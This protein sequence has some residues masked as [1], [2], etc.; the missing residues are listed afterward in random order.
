RGDRAAARLPRGT[1]L[2]R[3]LDEDDEP[4]RVDSCDLVRPLQHRP[5]DQLADERHAGA[6]PAPEADL[7][8]ERARVGSVSDAAARPRVSDANIRSAAPEA[9][10]ERVQARDVLHLTAA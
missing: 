9:S 10:P 2:G 1:H 8:R 6:L 7:G 5:Y 4:L 3:R